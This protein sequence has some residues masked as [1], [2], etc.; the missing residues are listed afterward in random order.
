MQIFYHKKT[1]QASVFADDEN[2]ADWS[3]YQ[4]T[5]PGPTEEDIRSERNNL[6]AQT[7]WRAS[8]DLTLD[9]DWTVY[10]QALRDVPAQEGFPTNVTWPT[11]PT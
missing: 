10:R 1:G 11:K 5:Q 7:D 4:E 9:S 3:D 2:I 6:L 8:T